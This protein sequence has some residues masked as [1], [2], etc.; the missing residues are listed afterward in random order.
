M[1]D[2]LKKI[3]AACED[4]IIIESAPY[5]LLGDIG[6]ELSKRLDKTGNMLLDSL[7]KI[8]IESEDA[9][10]IHCFEHGFR[11]G[12]NLMIDIITRQSL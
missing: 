1:N 7:T 3:Y 12:C 5:A 9:I 11:V 2:L 6:D 8:Q 4:E 10:S